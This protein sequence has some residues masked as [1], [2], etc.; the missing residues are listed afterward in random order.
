M[1]CRVAYLYVRLA[2]EPGPVRHE[3]V[4][5]VQVAQLLRRVVEPAQPALVAALQ[6]ELCA[7]RVDEIR[8]LVASRRLQHTPRHVTQRHECYSSAYLPMLST[9]YN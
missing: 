2:D 5:L 4:D 7:L 3:L 8:A 6:Q 9:L 1:R